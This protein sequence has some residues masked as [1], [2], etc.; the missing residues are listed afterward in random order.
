MKFAFNLE[1]TARSAI[2]AMALM[3]VLSASLVSPTAPAQDTKQTSDIIGTWVL[4]AAEWLACSYGLAAG[5]HLRAGLLC[6]GRN[7]ALRE[8]AAVGRR[9][10]RIE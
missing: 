6:H 9:P 10:L 8:P 2:A 7:L 5:R 4:A 3:V 1:G